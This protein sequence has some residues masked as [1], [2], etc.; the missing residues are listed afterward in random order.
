MVVD[1][2]RAADDFRNADILIRS[3]PMLLTRLG[4][5][6]F[7]QWIRT[8]MRLYDTVTYSG[9]FCSTDIDKLYR[10]NGGSCGLC[11][12]ACK[13]NRQLTN[14]GGHID[15]SVCYTC[16]GCLVSYHFQ[17]WEELRLKLIRD[18]CDRPFS[19]A[20]ASD[21][22]ECPLCEESKSRIPFF[23]LLK[24]IS[25]LFFLIFV[26]LI[27]QFCRATLICKFANLHIVTVQ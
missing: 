2:F 1:N 12:A 19:V 11:F 15:T 17:C 10:T 5:T 23:F 4:R 14:T 24:H 9:P 8:R 25:C 13:A 16:S 20:E 26:L 7:D 22:A 21:G 27:S 18:A 6:E 3:V